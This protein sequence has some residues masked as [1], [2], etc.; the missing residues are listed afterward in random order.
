M[1]GHK[2]QFF[3]LAQVADLLKAGVNP[4]DFYKTLASQ[5]RDGAGDALLEMSRLV[6]NGMAISDAMAHFPRLFSR[7]VIGIMRAGEAG[8]FLPDAARKASEMEHAAHKWNRFFTWVW[9]VV[10]NAVAGIPFA[11]ML[12]KGLTNNFWQGWET[13]KNEHPLTTMWGLFKHQTFWQIGLTF[14]FLLLFLFIWKKPMCRR[15]RHWTG[16]MYPYIRKRAINE[17]LMIFGWTLTRLAQSGIYPQR[18]YQLAADAIPN[19]IMATEFQN[20]GQGM[21]E[22]SPLSAPFAHN[23]YMPVEYQHIASTGEMTG[24][25]P[26]AMD[27]IYKLA[28]AEFD[29]QATKSKFVMGTAGLLWFT[30]T[31]LAIM[32]IIIKFYYSDLIDRF[33]KENTVITIHADF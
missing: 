8:G 16:L 14:G 3:H 23:K 18:A 22:N 19:D 31:G 28:E 10:I 15:A 32:A 17:S 27:Q 1:W 20:V 30:I 5:Q 11:L 13:G 21:S 7:N 24:S 4:A 6:A 12:A 25:V 33:L 29:Y 9:V 26:G 2:Q